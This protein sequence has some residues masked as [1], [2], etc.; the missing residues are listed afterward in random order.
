MSKILLLIQHYG[1]VLVFLNVLVEQAGLPIPAYPLLVICGALAALGHFSWLACLGLALLA[2]LLTDSAWYVAG[3]HYGRRILAL[4][5]RVS[6]SP[7]YCVSNTED[8]F[9]RWGI[10]SLLISKFVPGFN[11]IAPPMSGVLHVKKLP[12]LAF[13]TGGTLLWAGSALVLG[14]VFHRSIDRLL[15][16]LSTMGAVALA[17]FGFLFVAFLAVKYVER[18]RFMESLRMARITTDELADMIRDGHEPIIVDVR[19]ATARELEA[20]IPGAVLYGH[21]DHE[22]LFSELPR[23]R[24]IIVYCSCPNEASAARVARQMIDHGFATVRPLVGG[25]DAWN[26]HAAHTARLGDPA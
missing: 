15:D 17:V 18:R 13:A 21:D 3:R 19:S 26:A 6:L 10:K 25:L 14:A 7:D 12:Y 11:T 16:I 2:C 9:R 4:L 22:A 8:R 23:D 1:L 20:A 5:C 24:P